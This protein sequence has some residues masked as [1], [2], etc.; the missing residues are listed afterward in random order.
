MAII[1]C[2]IFLC[3]L[4][5]GFCWPAC[6]YDPTIPLCREQGVRA[7]VGP[8]ASLYLTME[9]YLF[10]VLT[11]FSFLSLVIM[12]PVNYHASSIRES[13]VKASLL[14]TASHAGLYA[15]AHIVSGAFVKQGNPYL[16]QSKSGEDS[17]VSIV[18][19]SKCSIVCLLL[20]WEISWH[21]G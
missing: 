13:M 8:D 9:L 1:P 10:I 19:T 21:L 18:V 11:I 15:S 4:V 5:V 16:F 2:E 6:T 17:T 12:V 3:S 14:T 7:R 20:A